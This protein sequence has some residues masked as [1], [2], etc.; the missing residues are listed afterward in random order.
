MD[1]D[2]GFFIRQGDSWQPESA[3]RFNAVNEMIG[4]LGTFGISSAEAPRSCS[5]Q[6]LVCRNISESFI[7]AG[8]YVMISAPKIS[9]DDIFK[10]TYSIKPGIQDPCGVTLADCPP[11]ETVDVQISGIVP[12]RKFPAP[13]NAAVIPGYFFQEGMELVNINSPGN[14]LYRNYFKVSAVG[15]DDSGV[16]TKVRIYDGADPESI[17]SGMTDVGEVYHEE[18]TGNFVRGTRFYV[19]LTMQKYLDAAWI[20][21]HIFEVNIE[22]SAARPSICLAEI[23][24]DNNVIQR[25]TGGMIYWRDRFILPPRRGELA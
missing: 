16:I 17:I 19:S 21:S 23:G 4:S 15:F 20:F 5:P 2:S 11:N 18:L 14:D 22:E 1:I 3:S 6:T 8:S 13:S 9:N 25:W 12:A 7:P 10:D 24:P